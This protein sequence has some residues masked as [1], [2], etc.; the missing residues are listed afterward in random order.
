[1]K[2]SLKINFLLII[3]IIALFTSCT[4]SGPFQPQIS[5]GKIHGDQLVVG[6]SFLLSSNDSLEGN[7][8][9]IGASLVIEKNARLKGDISLLGG[10]LDILG[11]VDGT[12]NNFAGVSH[13]YQSATIYGDIN[14]FLNEATIDSGAQTNG[15][16]NTFT[17]PRFPSQPISDIVNFLTGLLQP[18]K[19]IGLQLAH[20]IFYCTLSV[21]ATLIFKKR[22]SN[23]VIAVQKQAV[24]SWFFGVLGAI[25]IPL[26]GILLV[27][28]FCLSP[29][30]ILVIILWAL[31]VYMG[32]IV[33]GVFTG[34]VLQHWLHT[35][36]PEELQAFLG[37][38]VFGFVTS[39]LNW[40]PCIGWTITFCLGIT[41]LGGLFLSRF[42]APLTSKKSLLSSQ[43]PTPENI[44]NQEEKPKKK[45]SKS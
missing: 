16:I 37:S 20:L 8:V 39:L 23:V 40:L 31:L 30:G 11:S 6:N 34:K 36:W 42:G 29:V 1:M 7:I 15:E 10:T 32:W 45:K 14:Q 12:I 21:I 26:V 28:T 22:I 41:G 17:F 19:W 25:I 18:Q 24:V 2:L 3:A 43:Q 35:K 9:G 33:M 13:I 27:L 44:T 5:R 38:L 4:V